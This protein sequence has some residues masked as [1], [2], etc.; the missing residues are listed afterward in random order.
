[1]S[2]PYSEYDRSN[3]IFI[4]IMYQLNMFVASSLK[5]MSWCPA[6]YLEES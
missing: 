6:Q 3:L 4:V 2:T 1:M 5:G